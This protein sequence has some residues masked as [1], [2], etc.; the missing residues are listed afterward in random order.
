MKIFNSQKDIAMTNQ[1]SVEVVNR[2]SK[3]IVDSEERI[4]KALEDFQDKNKQMF[5]LSETYFK[6]QLKAREKTTE[7]ILD[8][9]EDIRLKLNLMIENNK[10]R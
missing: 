2:V 8:N 1:K 9:T 7:K 6:L 3:Y 10:K 4:I 5:K